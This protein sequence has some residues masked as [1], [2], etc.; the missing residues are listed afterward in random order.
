[1]VRIRNYILNDNATIGNWRFNGQYTG[2]GTTDFLLGWLPAAYLQDAC[3]ISPKLTVNLGI[4]YEVGLPFYDTQNRMANFMLTGPT[5]RV[6]SDILS[7]TL[8]NPGGFS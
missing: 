2:D 1:V 6:K 8:P 3:K 5:I 4:R 7:G